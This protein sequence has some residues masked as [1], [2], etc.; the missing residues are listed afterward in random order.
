MRKDDKKIQHNI[1]LDQINERLFKNEE[2]MV[3]GGRGKEH[4]GP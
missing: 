3:E 1:Y 2:L 4:E